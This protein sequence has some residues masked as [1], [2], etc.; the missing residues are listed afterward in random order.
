M[1]GDRLDPDRL[2]F[3]GDRLN[4]G[5]EAMIEVVENDPVTTVRQPIIGAVAF[6]DFPH[7]GA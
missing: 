7:D 5:D 2:P 1:L 3:P 6:R 4:P